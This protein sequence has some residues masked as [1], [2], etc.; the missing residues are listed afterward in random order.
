[1]SL[2]ASSES[3]PPC[4]AVRALSV[5]EHQAVMVVAGATGVLA[6]LG[7]ANS[8][9]KVQSA[10][11]SSFGWWAWTVPLG[12]DLGIAV[13]SALD[14]VLARLDMRTRWLRLIP[15]TLT[16]AT[17]YL[18]VS[19]EPTPFGVIAHAALPGLWVVAV[20]VGAHAIRVRA[21]LAAGTRMDRIRRSRWLLAPLTTAGLWRRMVLWETRSYP[22]ALRRERVRMLALAELQERYG[23]RWKRHATPHERALYRL[24]ELTPTAT[25]TAPVIWCMDGAAELPA[26]APPAGI[27]PGQPRTAPP[28]T[29]TKK[30]AVPTG[31]A[32]VEDRPAAPTGLGRVRRQA[33]TDAEL[34]D[35]LAAVERDEDG[36]V[37][38]RRAAR[39]LGCGPDRARR[40]LR[41]SGL[42]RATPQDDPDA[43]DAGLR[44][45]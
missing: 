25:S 43:D 20:E 23:R 31:P 11:A 24:G 13:F 5:R 14:I 40:L 34:T 35:V 28:G 18:N 16:A 15:W 21:G 4:D 44:I 2:N 29:P 32:P 36:T 8:F 30:P 3:P 9:A 6:V 10:A 12:I 39:A 38:V 37:P 19:T 7:F 42:L 22:Q 17:V 45:A 1:M 26:T 41:E 27:A 33:R